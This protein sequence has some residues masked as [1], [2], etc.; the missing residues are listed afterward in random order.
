MR[1]KNY[2]LK[3]STNSIRMETGLATMV[4]MQVSSL[5]SSVFIPIQD[6]VTY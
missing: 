3:D 6:G 5:I 4:F 1:L 2:I